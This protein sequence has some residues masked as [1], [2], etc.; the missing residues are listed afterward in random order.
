M[1][2]EI[3]RGVGTALITPHRGGEV[4]Y[5]ALISLIERQ[6]AAGIEAL[7]IGGTTG[8]AATLSDTER[9][10]LFRRAEDAVGGRAALIFGTGTN[11]TRSAI[12]HTAEA[13]RIGC[14]GVLV[15]TPYYNKGTREGVIKHYESI[16]DSTDLPI[17]LY[18]VPQ[19]TGVNL[20]LES[21]ARL[22]ERDNIVAIKE[23]SGSRE[24]LRQIAALDSLNLYAGNDADVG[25]VARL[26][27]S[28]VISVVSNLYPRRMQRLTALYLSGELELAAKE[29]AR[30]APVC[31]AMFVETNPAPLKYA[32]SKHGLCSGEMRL[33]M[34]EVGEDTKVLID[35]AMRG[36]ED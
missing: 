20:P 36:L 34:Y 35:A 29:E 31:E 13:E 5:A 28:G 19:R 33:P 1:K 21:I 17:I 23:A 4:D 11:D 16:A 26:G 25:E 12:R 30:L 15:V 6:I 3:F 14:D 27:G 10:E 8:E 9:Y 24:R 22:A 32:M 18:N 2:K 7:V